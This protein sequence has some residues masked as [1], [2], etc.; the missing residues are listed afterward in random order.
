MPATLPRPFT[1]LSWLGVP[2]MI[3]AFGILFIPLLASCT[4]FSTQRNPEADLSQIKRIHIESRLNDNHGIDRLIARELQQLG[5]IAST[6]PLTMLP[7]DADAVITYED[8]WTYDFT[9]HIVSLE[10]H[11]RAAHSDKKLGVGRYYRPSIIRKTPAEMT[12]E[13][14]TALFKPH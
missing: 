7:E 1:S 9:R 8:E 3:R 4:N 5:Y 13:V 12:H 11:L 6:G 10:V 2:L 14:I